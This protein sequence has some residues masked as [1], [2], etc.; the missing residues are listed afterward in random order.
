[1]EEEKQL[2][3]EWYKEQKEMTPYIMRDYFLSR[4]NL[5]V[6][7]ERER[8]VEEN[9]ARFNT[10]LAQVRIIVQNVSWCDLENGKGL[11]RN[12]NEI[13]EYLNLINTK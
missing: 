7:K 9:D 12:E 11:Y 8:I 4:I 6:S 1:M 10:M 13:I 3:D 5:A 2:F